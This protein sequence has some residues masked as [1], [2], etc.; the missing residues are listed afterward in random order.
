MKESEKLALESILDR[1]KK[2][3]AYV[4]RQFS[5]LFWLVTP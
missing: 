2:K 3:K 4:L 5:Q 1:M